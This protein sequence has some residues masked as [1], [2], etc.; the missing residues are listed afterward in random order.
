MSLF[1]IFALGTASSAVRGTSSVRSNS[2]HFKHTVTVTK[3]ITDCGGSTPTP[4]KNIIGLLSAT[5]TPTPTSTTTDLNSEE[6]CLD[7]F[8]TFRAS[9][10]L[11][12]FKAAT[13]EQ[14]DCA[15]KAAKYDAVQG[16]H[17]SFYGGLCPGAVSECECQKNVGLYD[18]PNSDPADPLKNC[19][20]AYIAEKTL[21]LYPQENL[22]HYRIITGNYQYLACGTDNNGFYT[23]NFYN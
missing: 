12:P 2:Y 11:A 19:I 13:V 21:G 1:A 9:L 22:G 17:A 10:G 20:N 14:I 23:H 16:Y 4:T 5:P 3:T 7:L 15:N 18:L 6:H 8:N